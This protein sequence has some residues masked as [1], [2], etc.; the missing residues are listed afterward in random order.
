MPKCD[1]KKITLQHGCSTVN[2]LHIFGTPFSKST[3][4]RLLLDLL[5]KIENL[6]NCL[7]TSMVTGRFLLGEFPPGQF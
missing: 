3:S 6:H 1:F 2:L 7:K 5:R 4:E